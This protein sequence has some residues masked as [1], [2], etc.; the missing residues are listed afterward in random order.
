MYLVAGKVSIFRKVLH[1][2]EV[3]DQQYHFLKGNQKAIC[4]C[5][6]RQSFC[7]ENISDFGIEIKEKLFFKTEGTALSLEC[8]V[9]TNIFREF[10]I[11]LLVLLSFL[12]IFD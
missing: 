6:R 11:L 9:L 4:F 3:F 2:N 5:G 8:H 10:L 1:W 7:L 12:I